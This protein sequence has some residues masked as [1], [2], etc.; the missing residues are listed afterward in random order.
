MK[1]REVTETRNPFGALIGVSSLI[2]ALLYLAG[3]SFRWSYYY[4]FGVQ[5]V[6]FKLNF[7]SFLVTAIELIREPRNFL[8]SLL[9]IIGP[10]IVANGVIRFI[11]HSA[12]I[13]RHRILSKCAA[14]P[15]KLF[16]L[17]SPLVVDAI[18]AILLLYSTF[19]LSSHLGYTTFK[20]HII[21]SPDNPLPAVTMIVED[22]ENKLALGCGC[23][24]TP[25]QLIGNARKIRIIQ[26]AYQT[27]NSETTKWRLLYRDD[28]SIYLFA[29]RSEKLIGHAR[30]LTLIMPNTKK[31]YL[32]M[33]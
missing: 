16:C 12:S 9:I 27:C 2:I 15:I 6:V 19:M 13:D 22:N 28:E 8:L 31:T 5:H 26:E 3:F 32:I 23:E 1:I 25:V 4:N 21:N 17:D 20:K 18:M 30:P 14:V 29:S 33:E 7:Q 24:E 11:K 10:L